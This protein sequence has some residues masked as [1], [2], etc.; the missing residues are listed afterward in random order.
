MT[1]LTL[2][3]AVARDGVIGRDNQLLWHLPEDMRHFKALTG[4]NAVIMGR[5]TWESL[6]ERFR[7][8]PNRRNIVISRDSAYVAPGAELVASLEAAVTA[9]FD[10]PAF[11]IGGAQIYALALPLAT[12]LELTAIDATFDGDAFFPAV[13][14]AVWREVARETA[15][16]EAGFNY[17]FVTYERR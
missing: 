12:R 3:A 7:P 5:K 2:V 15:R 8:L 14:T 6:P 10:L 16:A 17:A 4:G 9:A 1:Q 11:V 13:D